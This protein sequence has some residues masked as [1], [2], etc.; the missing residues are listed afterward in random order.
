MRHFLR[1]FAVSIL[2]L[3]VVSCSGDGPDFIWFR[4]IHAV[5]DAPDLRL[6]FDDYVYRER[7]VFGSASREGAESLLESSAPP[8]SMTLDYFAPNNL[9]G[10]TVLT[11]DVPI[12]QDAISTVVL[13][14]SFDSVEP[15]VVVSPRR[16]RPLGKL[17]FQFV[18]AVPGEGALDVYVTAPDTELTATAP[19]ATIQ[20]LG[21]SESLEV[22][23]GDTRI[24]LTA[25]GS[26]DV[27]MDS[28]EL[29]FPAQENSP[30]GPGS[31]WLF[32]VSPS[33]A[34]GPAPVF[35][36]GSNGRNTAAFFDEGTPATLRAFNAARSQPAVDVA[37]L[38]EPPELLVTD[39]GFRE[40][41]ALVAAP[42]G[43]YALQF[44][45]AGQADGA[46]ANV[47]V[48]TSRAT[49][50]A[51]FLREQEDISIASFV[52]SNTRAV[53]TAGKIRFAHL[54]PATSAVSVYLTQS[55][56]ETL[57]ASNRVL[58]Q[59]PPGDVSAHFPVPPGDYF[60][61]ITVLAAADADNDEETVILGPRPVTLAGGD[62]VTFGLFEPDNEGEP[63]LLLQFD[64]RM[65]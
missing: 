56:E 42:P 12:E 10:D 51:V 3:S 1:R 60:L 18:H 14:G 29:A 4:A 36:I 41:S 65:P 33:V 44:R 40:R 52:E 58:F 48:A 11:L 8:A 22:P 26:L 57:E 43:E 55:E 23:F 2:L 9:V 31:E 32:A 49:E 27:V 63:D 45:P 15:V 64:D 53:A 20:P 21:H 5:P 16:P 19:L 34:P 46:I 6:R 47:A 59:R 17:Y 50:Y 13:A 54:A 7:I 24:R 37:A 30:V 62:V 28:G 38:T 25:A 61:S 39:L 35:L